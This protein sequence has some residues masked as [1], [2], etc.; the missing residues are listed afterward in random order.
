[1]NHATRF[2][3]LA[4]ALVLVGALVLAGCGG[5]DG[6]NVEQDLRDQIAMLEGDLSSAQTAQAAAEAAQ[7]A[8]EEA[9]MEAEAAQTAAEMERDAANTAKGAAEAAKM[10]AEEAEAMAKAARMDAE[11]AQATAEAAQAAAMQAQTVAETERDAATGTLA[12]AQ[13]ARDAANEA[14]A[15]AQIAQAEAVTAAEAAR[16]AAIADKTRAEEAAAAA[17]MNAD[18]MVAAAQKAQMDAETAAEMAA[19][20][21]MDAETARDAAMEAQGTAEM[22]RDAAN[23]AKMEADAAAMKAEE[24]RKAAVAMAEDYKMKA[25]DA[26]DK[27]AKA[28]EARKAAVAA[29]MQAEA[30]KKTAEDELARVTGTVR[31]GEV[32]DASAQAKAL[33]AVLADNDVDTDNNSGLSAAPSDPASPTQAER[34]DV[35]NLMVEVSNDGLLMAV[36]EGDD[37]YTMSDMTPDMIDGWRGAMLTRDNADGTMDTVVVYT[38]I[39]NDG[40]QTLLDR[41]VSNLPTST[42]ARSWSIGGDDQVPWSEVSRPDEMTSASGPSGDPTTMFTGSVHGI[43]GTFSCNADGA[44]LCV[45]PERYSDGK[46]NAATTDLATS[47]MFVP[48]EGAATYTDDPNY[49]TFGWWLDKNAGGTPVDVRAFANATGLGGARTETSTLG[50]A[51]RGSAAYKGAAAG[52]YAIASTSDASYDGGHFTAEATLM[53]DFDADLTPVAGEASDRAGIS[54]SGTIDNFMTGSTARPDWMV[55]LMADANSVTD[56]VQTVANLGSAL[57]A[58]ADGVADGTQAVLTTEWSTGG[59]AK[60]VGTWSVMFDGGD[61]DPTAD[62]DIDVAANTAHPMAVTGMFDAHIGTAD[63]DAGAIARLQGAFGANKVME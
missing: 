51:L 58:D 28:E 35:S 54:L 42:R 14:A 2:M 31:E 53:A 7:M 41:Y 45:S 1:M 37:D 32:A 33:L 46:V 57:T 52:K 5:D 22:E 60:G 30:D 61:N 25:A 56:G 49:L 16:D 24:D 36:V 47:W 29:Q 23:T 44:A 39:G 17:R 26:E 18:E 62:A 21:Q 4:L 11:A 13:M 27:A 9:Q 6:G 55:K 15:A 34:N 20:A 10:A 40:T 3:R 38:D 43:P 59:A 12:A 50:T 8:A 48:E 63:A 19:Q